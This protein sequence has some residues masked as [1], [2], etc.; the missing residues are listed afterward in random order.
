MGKSARQF[1]TKLTKQI[2]ISSKKKKAKSVIKE[3]RPIHVS[4]NDLNEFINNR[5]SKK[6]T[7]FIF[8]FV[9]FLNYVC[10]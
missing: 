10:N 3:L 9:A 2:R 1:K 7:V 6:L 5:L 4:E 8:I